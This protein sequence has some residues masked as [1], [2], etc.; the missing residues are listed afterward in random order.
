[1]PG[2]TARQQRKTPSTFTSK[3]R[4]Q[5]S[6]GVSQVAVTGTRDAG[7]RDEQVDRA[8]LGLGPR[9]PASTSVSRETSPTSARPPISAATASTCAAVRPVTATRMPAAASSRAIPLPMPRPPPVT[10]A[11]PSKR[12]D[13]RARSRRAPRGSRATRGRPGPRPARPPARRGA[14]SS[15]CASSAG[16]RRTGDPLRGERLAEL[17]RD[18]VAHLGA[19]PSVASRPGAAR[20]RA[21]RP[22]PSRRAGTPI[23]AASATAGWRDSGRLELRRPDPLAGDVERVVASG[24]AGTSSRPRRPTPSR[25]ASRLRAS[26]TSTCRGSAR[27]RPRCP[28]SCPATACLQTSSPTSPRTGWPSGSKTSMSCPSAGKPSEHGFERRHRHAARG[29]RRRPRC[30]RSRLMIGQRAA[31]DALEQPAVRLGV[32]RLAG[33]ARIAQRREVV[34]RTGSS[35]CGISAR[36]SVGETPSIVMRCR[37]TRSPDRGP[38]RI[39]GRALVRARASRRSAAADHRPR[40]HDPAHVGGEVDAVAGLDVRLVRDLACD[41]HEEAR[42]GRAARPSACRS[43]PT[44]TRAGRDARSRPARGRGLPRSSLDELVPEAIAADRHR[45][46]VEPEP[47]PDDRMRST[48]G[49]DRERLVG[50]LLHRHQLS[51]T[52]R[53]VGRDQRFGLRVGEPRGDRRRGEAGEDRHLERAEVR[54]GV[55]GDRDLRRHRQEDPDRVALADAESTQALRRAERP[56]RTARARSATSRVPSSPC[57]IAASSLGEL[58]GRPLWTQ[59]QARLSFPPVNQVAHSSRETCPPP[60]PRARENSRP[61]SSISGRPEALGLLD[62][63]AV[64]RPG[65]VARRARARAWSGSRSRRSSR[66]GLQMKSDTARSVRVPRRRRSGSVL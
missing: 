64:E 62:R 12:S 28:A 9:H 1:M 36:T 56:R 48:V 66:V 63:D 57:Q 42:R 33:R 44:C 35:P 20:R 41:R 8:E 13:N 15:R 49:A 30:R 29:S 10:S 65:T 37:S 51:A 27:G 7:V 38:G 60:A 55:R 43:S 3:T 39:V 34:P 26:A 59:F 32:P 53:P 24:R 40:A 58:A 45:D 5:S 4:H 61:R 6:G 2:S 17:V 25:R 46:V 23:A 21:R 19:A 50:D 18:G 14:R 22:R 47:A 11:T 52:K 54:A 31:A 16:R